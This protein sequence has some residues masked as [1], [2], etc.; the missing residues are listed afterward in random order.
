MNCGAS[1][2]AEFLTAV[3]EADGPESNARATAERI[4]FDQTI[5]AEDDLLP[6]SLRATIVGHLEDLRQTA[7]G[8]YEARIRFRGDLLNGDCS[9]VLNVLFGTS[10]LRGDVTL[11]SFTMTKGLLSSW[12]GPQ[13]GLQGIRQ[14]VGIHDRPLLC[15]V[16]KPLGRS[17]EDLAKLAAEFVRGEIDLIKDDQS[18]LDQS[19]CP[20]EERVARCAEAIAQASVQRGRPCLYFAHVSGALDTM[21]RRALQAKAR[22]ATG[23]LIAPGLT[24]FDAMR[25]LSSDEGPDL[26][27]MSHPTFLGTLVASEKGGIAP[28]VVYGLLPRLAGADLTIYPAFG[29]DYSMSQQDCLSVAQSCR[30]SWGRLQPTMPA[31]GGRIG[32]ER[33]SELGTV[34]G[35]DLAFIVGSRIQQH[36]D[37]IRAALAALH[38]TMAE[39]YPSAC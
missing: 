34:L 38:R 6:L 8:R 22:G 7:G 27:V 14:A 13:V 16:L 4:C 25:S 29:S 39:W 17:P 31:V 5:E 15:G 9:D 1:D 37:G 32:P 26:P 28:A 12:R 10:S 33:L 3:Y 24:G 36:P 18:L 19:W 21:R 30:E 11:I 35:H 23:L 2:E 20:V